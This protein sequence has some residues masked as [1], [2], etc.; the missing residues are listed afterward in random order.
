MERLVHAFGAKQVGDGRRSDSIFRRLHSE[1]SN[2]ARGNGGTSV[3]P[4]AQRTTGDS[5]L[6]RSG[7][8]F[9]MVRDWDLDTKPK[10]PA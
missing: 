6:P 10:R 3:V 4:A 2:V 8:R 1:L 9:E 5:R 7:S